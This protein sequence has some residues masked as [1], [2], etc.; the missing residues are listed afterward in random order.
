[1]TKLLED[2]ESGRRPR[3]ADVVLAVGVVS[4]SLV[5]L[6]LL[7][8]PG[9]HKLQLRAKSAA[10][11][12][13]AATLQLAAESYAAVHQGR[14]AEQALDLLPYLPDDSAPKNPYTAKQITF[15]GA[16]GDLTYRSPSR[17]NDYVIQAFALGPG[18]RPRLVSTLTG[19]R[20]R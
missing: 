13:N 8:V 9:L 12:G 3:L 5:C 6:G 2:R 4:L 18:G 20:P 19:R 11:I 7:A 16:A 14:Y 10:V 15:G 1:M 17:G